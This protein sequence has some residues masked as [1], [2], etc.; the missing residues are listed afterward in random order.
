MS[1]LVVKLGPTSQQA[2]TLNLKYNSTF[3]KYQMRADHRTL[4]GKLYVY[5]WSNYIKH[6]INVTYMQ[7]SQAAIVNS[8]WQT[9]TELLL[10]ITSDSNTE[11]QSVVLLNKEFPMTKFVKPY[12]TYMEGKLEL[13]SY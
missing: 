2:I 1:S 4:S 7:T 11:V 5:L 12:N 3:S 13:E 8:W 6:K 10:F 9:N